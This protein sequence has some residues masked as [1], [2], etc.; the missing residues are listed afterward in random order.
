MACPDF[1]LKLMWEDKPNS[2]TTWK[3][4]QHLE[5]VMSP[6]RPAIP[7]VFAT[8]HVTVNR[9]LTKGLIL[10]LIHSEQPP[11]VALTHSP[12]PETTVP[13]AARPAQGGISTSLT[14]VTNSTNTEEDS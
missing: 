2:S 6:R 5:K 10:K 11:P 14:L 4:L 8:P 13:E 1:H 3:P 9:P 7:R 12:T